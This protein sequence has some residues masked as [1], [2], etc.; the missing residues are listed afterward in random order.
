MLQQPLYFQRYYVC[1]RSTRT[2]LK[3]HLS[4]LNLY[5]WNSSVLDEEASTGCGIR[6]IEAS[7]CYAWIV[8][9]QT[10]AVACKLRLYH[11]PNGCRVLRARC[12]LLPTGIVVAPSPSYWGSAQD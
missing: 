11:H 7:K 4:P 2:I 9:I 12:A 8:S 1:K 10:L 3:H 5:G 6:Q